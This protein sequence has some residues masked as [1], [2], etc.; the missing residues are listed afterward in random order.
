MDVVASWARIEA[1]ARTSFPA[2]ARTLCDGVSEERLRE[3]ESG[4][5]VVIPPALRASLRVHE[6]Q[7]IQVWTEALI[8]C[9]DRFRL[10]TLADIADRV[11]FAR[12][13]IGSHEGARV[14]F[15]RNA[16][17]LSL[18]IAPDGSITLG[19]ESAATTRRYADFAELLRS[20]ADDLEAGRIVVRERG[21]EYVRPSVEAVRRATRDVI[22]RGEVRGTT[23][24]QRGTEIALALANEHRVP[25]FVFGWYEIEGELLDA[26]RA[27]K[28]LADAWLALAADSAE[29]IQRYQEHHAH[30]IPRS[31]D[32]ASAWSAI[33]KSL[34][35]EMR[36]SLAPGR[37]GAALESVLDRCLAVHDGQ[38]AGARG[39]I[40]SGGVAYRILQASEI[41]G[42]AWLA[43]ARSEAGLAIVVDRVCGHVLLVHASAQQRPLVLVFE[44][45]IALLEDVGRRAGLP[46]SWRVIVRDA[47]RGHDEDI[48]FCKALAVL[49]LDHGVALHRLSAE[50]Y[51]EIWD[52][53]LVT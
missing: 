33:E 4:L 7:A 40:E 34:T 14:P 47:T 11:A 30:P 45:M 10:M 1:W 5:A 28:P 21:L 2:L 13:G 6:G 18:W 20:L 24:G 52:V 31:G 32:A 48:R 46:P 27:R 43:V 51:F 39:L 29:A 15:A 26:A 9:M 38:R 42:D 16:E 37:E 8:P 35:D 19:S 12:R 36:A 50:L 25:A 17:G 53:A 49:A 3:F 44:D 41:A 23:L 22:A